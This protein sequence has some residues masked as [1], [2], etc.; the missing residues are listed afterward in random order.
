M[1]Q[2]IIVWSLLLG[3]IGLIW[4]VVLAILDDT[5]TAENRQ[6]GSASSERSDGSQPR[7]SSP[8]QSRAA[9]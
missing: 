2:E 5:H 4:V 9:A 1:T 3:L 7:G 6:N 8:Q